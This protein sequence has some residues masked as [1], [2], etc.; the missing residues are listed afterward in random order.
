MVQ[1]EAVPSG[2]KPPRLTVVFLLETDTVRPVCLPNPGLL[3]EPT[4]ACWISGW[5][6]TY[7]KG[8]RGAGTG[9]R[10]SVVAL[11]LND[12]ATLGDPLRLYASVSPPAA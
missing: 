5:G 4:Q 6:S 12:G 3:L 9:S 8:E 7:E 11:L 1:L 10:V 2:L